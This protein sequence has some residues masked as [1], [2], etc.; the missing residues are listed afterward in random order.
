M[1]D[2]VHAFEITVGSIVGAI[3]TLSS[4]FF[5]LN[6][7]KITVDVKYG[8]NIEIFTSLIISYF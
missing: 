5:S 6:V 8:S 7:I 1:N 2:Y 4:F 3:A